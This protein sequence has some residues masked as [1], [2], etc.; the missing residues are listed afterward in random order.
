MRSMLI[1]LAAA[2]LAM[3]TAGCGGGEEPAE[4][5]PVEE[6]AVET[7]ETGDDGEADSA[8]E[9]ETSEEG[10]SGSSASRAIPLEPGRVE[11]SLDADRDEEWYVF[12]LP[13]GGVLELT[14]APGEDT[15]RMNVTLLDSEMG[16]LEEE[17]DVRPPSTREFTY[18]IPAGD[19]QDI[20]VKVSQGRPG[21]YALELN[22]SMQDDAGS[23]GDAPGRAVEAL[24][25][26]P[27]G[28]IPGLVAD[29]DEED[30]YGF[31]LEAGQVLELEFTPGDDAERLNVSL[32]D[33]DQSTEWEEWDVSPGVTKSYT[34]QLGGEGGRWYVE[35]SRGRNGSYELSM[36]VSAQNDATTGGDA[37]N[38]AVEATPVDTLQVLEGRVADYDEDDFYRLQVEEGE[39]F[40]LAATPGADAE[41]LNFSVLD[42][43]Q[44]EIWEQWDVSAGVTEE[45]TL[46]GDSPPG[47]YYIRVSQGRD[48]DYTLEIR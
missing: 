18:V 26:E 34:L 40:T 24:E 6:E 11:A 45:F 19:P 36:S 2:L 12:E 32:L 41:R 37:G 25:V 15:E 22:I 10:E 8:E 43:E 14:F 46:P 13:A 29:D 3:G 16:V 38:R 1:L 23:G 9:G 42:P 21:T 5:R 28:T 4:E 27:E 39:T 47:P 33:G 7:A 30:W 20:Y 31:D 17:W 35:V 48:G 44:S